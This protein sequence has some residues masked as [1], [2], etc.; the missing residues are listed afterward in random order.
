MGC[1]CKNRDRVIQNP[2]PVETPKPIE[3]IDYFN[4]IDII[5]PINNGEDKTEGTTNNE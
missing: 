2:R 3:E 4:N 5:T 1:N